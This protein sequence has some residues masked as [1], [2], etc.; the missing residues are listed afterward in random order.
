MVHS[1]RGQ[2]AGRC[3]LLTTAL[4]IGLALPLLGQ[5]ST[6]PAI[7][8]VTPAPTGAEIPLLEPDKPIRETL[9]GGGSHSYRILLEVGQFAQIV[10]EQ[11]GLDV[12]AT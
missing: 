9:A 4:A 2:F 1:R 11:Q 10:V 12:V 8:P 3:L 5:G 6:A 7:P